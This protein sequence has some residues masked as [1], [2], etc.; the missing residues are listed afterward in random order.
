[1]KKVASFRERNPYYLYSVARKS[2][3]DT[4]HERAVKYY[5][6]AIHRKD[7]D[8]LFYYGLAMAYLKLWDLEKAEKK[9]NKAKY[10]AWDEDKKAYY[11]QVRD[12][13]VNTTP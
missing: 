9:I 4:F 7:D 5:K 13:L 2:Y 1:M 11:D 3:H 10:Y 8:H 6:A 12:T